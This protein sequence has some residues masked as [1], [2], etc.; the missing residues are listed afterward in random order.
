[1]DITYH[2]QREFNKVESFEAFAWWDGEKIGVG[3]LIIQH[4]DEG[5]PMGLIEDIFVEEAHRKMGIG[6]NIV[7]Q[8]MDKA[9]AKNVYKIV[10]YC[11]DLNIPLYE[12]IGFKIDQNHMTYQNY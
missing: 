5:R 9:L 4:K 8:L 12:K 2:L 3:K 6:R 10:L 11:S 7:C 1:M